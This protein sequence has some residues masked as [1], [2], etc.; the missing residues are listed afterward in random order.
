MIELKNVFLAYNKEYYALYD[1]SLKIKKGEK[2]ALLGQEGSGKTALLRIIAGLEKQKKGEAYINNKPIMKINF[3]T[4]VNLGYI[5]SKAVFMESKSVYKNLAYVL[6]IRNVNRD[7]WDEQI[8]K[9]L[10]EFEISHLKNEKTGTLCTSDR[11]LV[12]IARLALRPLDIILCDDIELNVEAKT[13]EKIKKAFTKLV[14]MNKNSVVI[15]ACS[16]IDNWEQ[17]V[18]RVIKINSGS[19][20]GE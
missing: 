20:E 3:E 5:T 16:K 14:E 10:N 2:V 9:V 4:D 7:L 11:R 8:N 1:I 18:S 6:K 12:Q 19:L 17:M 15:V 13:F